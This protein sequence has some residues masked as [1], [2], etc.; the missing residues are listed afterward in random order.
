MGI[1][2]L[3]SKN[4]LTVEPIGKKDGIEMV[5]SKYIALLLMED[6]YLL[7]KKFQI[8]KSFITRL[9]SFRL[10]EDALLRASLLDMLIKPIVDNNVFSKL[11]EISIQGH[12]TIEVRRLI[13]DHA[14]S[15]VEENII[16]R[17]NRIT[18]IDK[19]IQ[20]F[21]L[22]RAEFSKRIDEIDSTDLL[23]DEV[24]RDKTNQVFKNPFI[25]NSL[26]SKTNITRPILDFKTTRSIENDAIRSMLKNLNELNQI[27]KSDILQRELLEV[28]TQISDQ[29]HRIAIVGE[30]KHGKSSLFNR[31]IGTDIS[32][33]GEGTATTA[34]VVELHYSKEAK[35]EAKWISE[36]GLNKRLNYINENSG[37]THVQEYAFILEELVKKPYFAP[38]QTFNHI[39]STYDIY[40]YVC[41]KGDYT[42]G[43]ERVKID[44]PVE[45][46]KHG[47]ILID[48]P[49]LNDP[50]KVRDN[51]TKEQAIIADTI[52]FVM[53]A[54]KFGT[55]SERQ[56]LMEI[57][58]KTRAT[59]LMVVLT[60]ID[61]RN[62]TEDFSK[63]IQEVREWLNRV[64][65]NPLL[66]GAP[67]FAFNA[68]YKGDEPEKELVQGTG[69]VSF[70][71]R[72]SK[73]ADVSE[74]NRKYIQW[75]KEKKNTLSSIAQTEVKRF[76]GCT[77]E[78]NQTLQA[79]NQINVLIEQLEN[80]NKAY[81]NQLELRIEE[82]KTKLKDDY[83]ALKIESQQCQRFIKEN[84]RAAIEAKVRELGNKYASKD[85]WSV[86]NKDTASNIIRVNT[87]Q[88]H[89]NAQEIIT[90]WG[91]LVNEFDVTLHND[92][93]ENAT[94]IEEV[95]N[96]FSDMSF[97]DQQLIYSLCQVNDI[98]SAL[99][100]TISKAKYLGAGY[101]ISTGV[102]T[103][104]I[105]SMVTGAMSIAFPPALPWVVGGFTIAALTAKLAGGFDRD[106]QKYNFIENKEKEVND[107]V[108]L[109]FE[110]YN[111]IIGNEFKIFYNG[112]L[113][114]IN[115]IYIPIIETARSNVRDL[116]LQIEIAEKM[117]NDLLNYSHRIITEY[118]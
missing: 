81:E 25:K 59:S 64:S 72:I 118:N 83:E 28:G 94:R 15:A 69:F 107:S 110:K 109:M 19:L 76:I 14:L 101:L 41:T 90:S 62:E 17:K 26:S 54:D 1:I 74:Q 23:L 57:L 11:L 96:T 93:E 13:V 5:S 106:K 40:N 56:F 51:I 66:F 46:L 48:T 91:K 98:F 20:T 52:I 99:G 80:V 42:A 10:T 38:N 77:D 61:R 115:H 49:G 9:F 88:L 8:Y 85:K 104:T 36:E 6:G 27:I 82:M 45:C 89:F 71:Q 18:E 34:A 32:P 3:K 55:E 75:L 97:S 67:I 86:F 113:K 112:L 58:E 44:S 100:K 79:M 95:R 12:T 4:E 111:E 116:K 43:V 53:R 63:L 2:K 29:T 30:I 102:A 78:N 47:A 68:A 35:Y 108:D 22:S 16:F 39:H 50:M 105:K 92:F 33:V 21:E 87:Q 84:L 60:H 65:N 24:A 70:V 117:K 31:L 7:P 114:A 103:A 73:P 37:N